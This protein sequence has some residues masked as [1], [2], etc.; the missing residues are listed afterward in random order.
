MGV[1]AED[2]TRGR[3]VEAAP[4]RIGVLH[5]APPAGAVGA[6]VD[7]EEVVERRGERQPFEEGAV[8][9]RQSRPRPLDGD[10]R[11]L[12]HARAAP[13]RGL[14]MVSHDGDGALL[15]QPR[16][17]LDAVL[18]IG[19]VADDVAEDGHPVDVGRSH[20]REHGLESLA[21]AMDVGQD[22]DAHFGAFLRAH[23]WPGHRARNAALG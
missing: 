9:L 21:V 10:L 11:I 4:R 22:C 12:R 15:H 13:Q 2:V 6:G 20:A 23:L 8:S 7:E 16:N 5:V 14:V 17:P 18:G 19:P 3:G 1:A